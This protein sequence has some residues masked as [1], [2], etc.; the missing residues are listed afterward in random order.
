MRRLGPEGERGWLGLK[1]TW[2]SEVCATKTRTEGEDNERRDE[3]I[4]RLINWQF[5]NI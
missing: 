1:T 5:G 4:D 3:L 2:N